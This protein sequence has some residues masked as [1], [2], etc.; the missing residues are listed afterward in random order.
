[1]QGIPGAYAAIVNQS[2]TMMNDDGFLV[3]LSGW[4]QGASDNYVQVLGSNVFW[5]GYVSFLF[6]TP[7]LIRRMTCFPHCFLRSG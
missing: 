5:L 1:V 4:N 7:S 2:Q 3:L 6:C